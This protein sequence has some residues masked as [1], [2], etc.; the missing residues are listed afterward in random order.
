MQHNP[1]SPPNADVAEMEAERPQQVPFE[2]VLAVRVLWGSVLL[3]LVFGVIEYINRVQ[4]NDPFDPPRT[5]TTI[6]GNCFGLLVATWFIGKIAKGRN[7]A[8]I[9]MLVFNV[10]QYVAVGLIWVFLDHEYYE[11]V[12]AFDLFTL[13]VQQLLTLVALYLV[14]VSAGRHWFKPPS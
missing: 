13:A 4:A 14:F 7:W 12:G 3:G 2:V 5:L 8:R 9:L 11:Q 1:Y 6:L 10:L